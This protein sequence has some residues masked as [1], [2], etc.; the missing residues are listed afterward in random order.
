MQRKVANKVQLIHYQLTGLTIASGL[1]CLTLHSRPLCYRSVYR[2]L[3]TI[4]VAGDLR[5][6][7]TRVVINIW[8]YTSA[9]MIRIKQ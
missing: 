3:R 8:Q 9:E 5:C 4:P 7:V 2:I 1:E 6:R